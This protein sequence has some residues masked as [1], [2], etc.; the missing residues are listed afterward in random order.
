MLGLGGW[1]VVKGFG[2]GGIDNPQE[3]LHLGGQWKIADF[4]ISKNRD[5]YRSGR[6]FQGAGTPLYMAPEQLTGVEAHPSANVFSLGRLFAFLLSGAPLL[7]RVP[8]DLDLTS[9]DALDE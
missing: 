7:D 4:G 6:T 1:L 5:R 8:T 2:S 9:G 3:P